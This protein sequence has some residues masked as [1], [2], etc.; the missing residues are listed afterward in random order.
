V[1]V[2]SPTKTDDNGERERMGRLDVR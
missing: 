1:N 2:G